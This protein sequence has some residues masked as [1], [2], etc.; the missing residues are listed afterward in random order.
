MSVSLEIIGSVA[1]ITIARPRDGGAAARLAYDVADVAERVRR[2]DEVWVAALDLADGLAAPLSRVGEMAL[3]ERRIASRIAEIEQPVVCALRGEVYDQACEIALAADIRIA[4]AAA[5]FAM[6]QT[7]S[8]GM[9][10]DGGTQRL[11]RLIGRSRAVEMML[12]G[13]AVGAD[14]ALA[15]GLVNEVVADGS[16]R[17]R[18]IQ[19]AQTIAAHGPI[20]LRYLKEAVAS[21]LD[22]SLDSGLRLEADLGFLLQSTDDRREGIA[23]FLE[24]RA[25]RYGNS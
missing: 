20:A 1:A 12:T 23:S 21:G 8:G 25:P 9:A 6:R 13:R 16:A 3:A 24:R 2:S 17:E 22:G 14:E 4:D 15:M 10:W 19:L 7:V 18:A 11:P 5:S